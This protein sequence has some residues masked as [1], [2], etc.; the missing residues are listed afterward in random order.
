M[1]MSAATFAAT[2]AAATW[3][4]TSAAAT[5]AATS[6]AATWAAT[7]AAATLAATKS[8][9]T[10]WSKVLYRSSS[11]CIQYFLTQSN[12]EHVRIYYQAIFSVCSVIT[13][14]TF[15]VIKVFR[16]HSVFQNVLSV[17]YNML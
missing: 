9:T 6:A 17:Q 2:T 8:A 14:Y 11:F 15:T 12:V 4:A 1:R 3:A 7:A 16:A 5:W 10:P 13:C